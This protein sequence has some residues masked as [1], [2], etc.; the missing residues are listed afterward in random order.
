MPT[1]AEI[2]AAAA[3]S[4]RIIVHTQTREWYGDDT[5]TEGRYKMKGGHA[6]I[7]T[8]P[9]EWGYD[10]EKVEELSKNFNSKYNRLGKSYMCYEWL[11]WDYYTE[12]TS[13]VLVGEELVE[14]P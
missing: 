3:S 10:Y 8:I 14:I 9:R 1:T 11:E 4:L 12:P 5:Y 6:F 13:L 7:I 2:T